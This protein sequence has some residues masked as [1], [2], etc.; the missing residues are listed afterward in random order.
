MKRKKNTYIIVLITILMTHFNIYGKEYKIAIIP[1]SISADFWRKME[2]GVKKAEK[3]FNVKVIFRGPNFDENVEAQMRIVDSFINKKYDL[4]AIA[5]GDYEK[6]YPLLEKAQKNKIRVI[7]FDSNLKGEIHETFIASDNYNAGKQA[8]EEAVKFLNKKSKV[9][10]L[11][12]S[13]GSGSTEKREEG[14]LKKIKEK[15]S[16]IKMEYGGTSVGSCFRK[17]MEE[18]AKGDYDF[19]FTP[20]ENTTSGMIKALNKLKLKKKPIHI[21]FDFSNDI[22]ESI[23]NGTTYGAIVQDPYK[24]GYMTV[25]YSLDILKNIPVDKVIIIDTKFINKQ[26]LRSIE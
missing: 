3:D 20:N 1:K 10:I 4:I 14:F 18:I 16:N 21:G 22:K 26:N 5:P 2:D 12:Y 13:K 6:I 15:T 24:M 9:F 19:I 23:K 17:S 11:Q 8:G 7:G 25:K